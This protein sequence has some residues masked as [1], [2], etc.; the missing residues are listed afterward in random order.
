MKHNMFF[1]LTLILFGCQKDN[2]VTTEQ[3]LLPEL[4]LVKVT[5]SNYSELDIQS[6]V[7]DTTY[8]NKCCAIYTNHL[9]DSAKKYMINVLLQKAQ[10]LNQDT[11]VVAECLNATGQLQEGIVSIPYFAEQAKYL[12]KECWIFEFAWG[13][14]T[15]DLGHHRCF[16]MDISTKDTLLFIT[17][18]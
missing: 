13:A 12:S 6:R 11:S 17:C 7:P 2:P 16:V 14:S 15:N 1:F 9:T 4:P 3:S 5:Q 18:K 8:K 10:Q